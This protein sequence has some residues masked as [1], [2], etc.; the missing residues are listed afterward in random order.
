MS[1]VVL[2]VVGSTEF[3]KDRTASM[4]ATEL[5]EAAFDQYRPRLVVSGGAPGIDRLAARLARRRGIEVKEFPA[6][7]WKW[8]G[9][10]GF[11]ERNVWVAETCTHLLAIRHYNSTTYGSGWT[12]DEAEKRGKQVARLMVMPRG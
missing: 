11:K 2:A 3:E 4:D 10:G 5:I 7:V 12:A 1:D 6:K 8:D 9:E